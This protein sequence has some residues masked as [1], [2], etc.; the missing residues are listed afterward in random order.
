M[1]SQN[2]GLCLAALTEIA[3]L[4]ESTGNT[5]LAVEL[6]SLVQSQSL[7]GWFVRGKA[8]KLLDKLATKLPPEIFAE[9]QDRCWKRDVLATAEEMNAV[10]ILDPETWQSVKTFE[11]EGSGILTGIVWSP[12]GNYLAA[13]S[14]DGV[15]LVWE[16]Q[17]GDM[18]QKLSGHFG[19]VN[20][21]DWSP[22]GKLLASGGDGFQVMIWDAQSGELMHTLEN[23]F[24]GVFGVAWSTDGEKL[25][26]VALD[27][28][29]IFWE[30]K[31]G[32]EIDALT[33]NPSL[34]SVAWSPD[35]TQLAT[36]TALN[37]VIVWDIAT[38]EQTFELFIESLE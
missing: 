10:T 3:A 36:G 17:N 37:T 19:W 23:H 35:G 5:T 25:A 26:S 24:A 34:I 16:I 29:V 9:T 18:T 6:A 11:G 38:G 7:S 13:S 31:S 27:G 32:S 12:D 2:L 30:S 1:I 20:D 8:M 33:L 14:T 4:N 22:D 28:Q 21:L 15:I